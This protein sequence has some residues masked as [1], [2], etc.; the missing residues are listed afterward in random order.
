[1]FSE[2]LLQHH[3]ASSSLGVVAWDAGFRVLAWDGASERIFGWTAAEALGQRIDALRIIHEDDAEQV[4]RVMDALRRA[5]PH[6]V[7]RNRNRTRDGQVRY[8][9][10]NNTVVTGPDGALTSVLSIVVDRTE[11]VLAEERLWA[12]RARLQAL[13][14]AGLR[15]G[16][17]LD[18][19][20]TLAAVAEVV[21]SSGLA[22]FCLVDV[23]CRTDALA[24]VAAAHRDPARQPL[25]DVLRRY[26]PAREDN[27]VLQAWRDHRTIRVREPPSDELLER[28]AI[29]AEHLAAVLALRTR[30]AL[31]VPLL[32][33]ERCIGVLTLGATVGSAIDYDDE[34]V[35]FAEELARRCAVAIAHATAFAEERRL[36]VEREEV[37]RR[38]ELLQRVTAGLSGAVSLADVGVVTLE[39]VLPHVGA[40]AGALIV[41]EKEGLRIAYSEGFP[42]VILDKYGL[43][44]LDGQNPASEAARDGRARYFRD[45]SEHEATYPHLRP[46][47]SSL[48]YQALAVL[49]L[50]AQGRVLGV[51]ALRFAE[52]RA[53]PEVERS[54]LETVAEQC[55]QAVARARLFETERLARAEADRASRAKD[56]FLAMLGHELRNPLAPIATTAQIFRRR[57]VAPRETAVLERQVAHLTRLVDDLLDVSRIARGKIEIE[58]A[59]L[60]LREVVAAALESVSP[61]CEQRAHQVEVDLPPTPLVVLGDRERLVQVFS[62]LLTNAARYTEP[63]GRVTVRGALVDGRA[64]VVVADTGIGLEPD[65]LEAAFELFVQAEQPRDRTRGGLGIGLTIVRKLVELHGGRVVASSDGRGRGAA[66]TVELPAHDAVATASHEA[67]EGPRTRRSGRVLLVDDNQDAALLLAE[68]LRSEGYTVVTAHDGPSALSAASVLEPQLALLDLG[69]PLMDGY[70]VGS[71]LRDALGAAVR[72]VAL[73]GYGQERDVQ[74]SREHGFDAH[75]VKPVDMGRLFQEVD[76]LLGPGVAR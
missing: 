45:A 16:A 64:T 27:Q 42:K 9:E 74:R 2:D 69:L 41:L 75:F 59:P 17:S 13:A 33:G 24:R 61:L 35:S 70:E 28:A 48:G 32:I 50:R 6:V 49:P 71:R 73:T 29:N 39:Q 38:L 21:V 3:L 55:A 67:P 66:F 60:D 26:P 10:W 4:G 53:F 72:L 54:L 57:G 44:P 52:A 11:Q 47:A 12:S 68:L 19:D 65:M 30:A 14:L 1:M 25:L 5:T 51:L 40:A 34:M 31:V 43:M 37:S 56:E 7:S 36:R 22:D 15:L 63:A 23:A 46:D 18:Y 62:N 20:Q 58:R 76:R 8:C